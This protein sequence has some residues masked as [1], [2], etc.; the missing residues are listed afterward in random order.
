MILLIPFIGNATSSDNE[1]LS[2]KAIAGIVFSALALVAVVLLIGCLVIM[3]ASPEKRK[4]ML[5]I[6]CSIEYH[7]ISCQNAL[8]FVGRD[9]HLL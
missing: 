2:I 8:L 1:P 4:S 9:G 5:A 7:E 3:L 6:T